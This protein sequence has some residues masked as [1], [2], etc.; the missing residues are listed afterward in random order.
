MK[1]VDLDL[2]KKNTNKR[3][4]KKAEPKAEVIDMQE[5][6][7]VQAT[8]PLANYSKRTVIKE[9]TIPPE[10]TNKHRFIRLNFRSHE[11]STKKQKVLLTVALSGSILLILFLALFVYYVVIPVK[12]VLNAANAIQENTVALLTD[13][14]G[15]DLTNIDLYFSDIQT[16]IDQINKEL[17]RYEFLSKL[18]FTKGYYENFQ[19]AKG[20]LD[21]STSLL[22]ETLPE[23][24][25]VLQAT[26]FKTSK[27]QTIEVS[28]ETTSGTDASQEDGT[29]TLIMRELPQYLELYDN[30]EPRIIG[31]LDDIKKINPEY[32]PD[33][34]GY[35]LKDKYAKARDFVDEFPALSSKTKNFVKFIP[36]LIGANKQ[37]NYLIILQSEGEMRSS[38]GLLTAYG[39]L[40]INK[41]DLGDVTSIVDMWYLENNLRYT[42]G[43]NAGP[44]NFS[45]YK[46]YPE[47]VSPYG[48]YRN[49]YG[50]DW[51]MASNC[52]SNYLRAQ[53]SGIY[54]DLNWV[55]ETFTDY[56]DIAKKYDPKSYPDYD[57]VLIANNAFGQNLISLIQPL[58]IEGFGQVTSENLYQFIK[59]ETDDPK[60]N[61][62]NPDRKSIIKE[63]ANAAKKKFLDMPISD[64]PKIIEALIKSFNARD[65][66]LES[67]KDPVMQKYF[68]DYGM[69][70]KFVKDYTGDYFHLNE[71]QNCS[72][73][74]NQWVRDS[75]TQN[76][77]IADD[78]KINK[79]VKIHWTQPKIYD[80]SLTGQYADTARFSYRA[81]VRLMVPKESTNI[82]S[83]GYKQSGYLF[84]TPQKYYDVTMDK[85][86]SDNIIQ[87][88]HRRFTEAD[89]ID[90]KDLTVSYSLP[91]SINYKKDGE[92][93]LILQKHA[94]KSWGE[95]YKININQG[96]STYTVEFD[97]DRDKILTY[98]GGI[99][100]VDNYDKKLDWI[101]EL[102]NRIPW[103]KLNKD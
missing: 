39:N 44:E 89:P 14:K 34:A 71:A 18:D 37:T 25:T 86:V 7:E 84:Y 82:K 47:Y 75:V 83:D 81:W 67:T 5:V 40:S 13:F 17:D 92:Y 57:Y 41:G 12:R 61:N 36:N 20:I 103:D 97:L 26:G 2:T 4:R 96:G 46:K 68:D 33:F 28:K 72:L 88:D 101:I 64:F 3:K 15:R 24:K 78:G 94:G 43:I 85:E 6:P 60:Y 49:I 91:D 27:N 76:V 38:G 10:N 23:L 70:G 102:A 66:A 22:K 50:Q 19:V 93:S 99:I 48:Y 9:V 54:P 80:P 42:L 73:K 74:L 16:E 51:L 11:P 95:P 58:D 29:L 56:Y 8:E 100:S 45:Y 90:K 62:Y 65:V 59:T 21:K 35:N 31:I 1:Q 55:A 52:G 32:L 30:V 69:S 53:D 79:E 63:I 87:F 77:T 98:S